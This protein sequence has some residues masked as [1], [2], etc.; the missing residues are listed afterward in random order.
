MRA[1]I[2]RTGGFA[3]LRREW[4]LEEGDLTAAEEDRLR[5]LLDRSGFFA[6]SAAGAEA[7]REPA[8]PAGEA[9]RVREA[10]PAPEPAEEA[11]RVRDAFVYE[12][13]VEDAGRARTV[14]C[15]EP[16]LTPPLRE[17]LE[18]LLAAARPH[19]P[20]PETRPRAGP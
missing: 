2:V 7:G 17:C 12:I 8:P 1:R 6:A 16:A 20:G 3:G 11:A 10:A 14:R 18:A 13:A 19:P 5:R 4:R 15:A 9:G